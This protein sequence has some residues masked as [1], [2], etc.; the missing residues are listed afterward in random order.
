M[1]AAIAGREI[2][3]QP[4]IAPRR[5]IPRQNSP[6]RTVVATRDA[7]REGD[8][9]N[10][11]AQ[12]RIDIARE[13]RGRENKT[14]ES[15]QTTEDSDED[16]CGLPCF[17]RR[18]H[19][20]RVPTSFNLPDRGKVGYR[21]RLRPAAPAVLPVPLPPPS[22]A[23]ATSSSPPTCAPHGKEPPVLVGVTSAWRCRAWAS[24]ATPPSRGAQVL[25]RLRFSAAPSTVPGRRSRCRGN[26]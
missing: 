13:E 4:K 17:T 15:C 18:V 16:L 24:P 12:A 21:R 3:P 20:T 8:A 19:K 9:S 5:N 14:R 7:P 11:V 6:R 10:T 23:M 26:A 1:G 22:P 2:A 25:A